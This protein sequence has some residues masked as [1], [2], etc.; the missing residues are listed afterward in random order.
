MSNNDKNDIIN[1]LFS[2]RELEKLI[3]EQHC[4]LDMLDNDL[5]EVNA[6]L[7][8]PAT[9]DNLENFELL[10]ENILKEDEQGLPINNT[11]FFIKGKVALIP[12]DIN[13]FFD[14]EKKGESTGKKDYYAR[15]VVQMA[16]QVNTPT[17][18]KYVPKFTKAKVK[19]KVPLL[20][21]NI[22][23]A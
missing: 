21:K 7:K 19:P 15:Q 17:P 1:M 8:L 20:L 18:V 10:Q 11:P 12:K 14:D 3:E 2:C 5:R 22:T 16:T 23:K 13:T 6:S 9:W 4:V